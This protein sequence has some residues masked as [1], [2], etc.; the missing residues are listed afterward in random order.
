MTEHG[1][2][3]RRACRLICFDRSTARY[4]CRRPDDAALRGRLRALAA[5]RR[6][7]GYRRLGVLLAREGV[8]VNHKKLFRLYREERLAVRRR[9]GRKRAVGTRRPMT[10][11]QVVNER[12]SLDF[13][14]DALG[15]GRRFRVL[16]VLDD[17]SREC[18]ALIV[19]TS[20]SGKRVARELDQLIAWRGRPA[21]I[22]S[23]NGTELTSN[24]I[25]CWAEE[26]GVEW[27]YIAP[28]KPVQN[29]FAESFIG[30]F[31]DEC[32]NESLFGSLAAA[33]RLIAHWRADY[34][35]TRPHSSL[36]NR[37]PIAYANLS[38]PVMRRGGS[39]E[40][41]GGSAPRLVAPQTM[42]MQ[43]ATGL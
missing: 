10:I 22:V 35:A 11:P 27:H 15:D 34:N 17:F 30:R 24:A 28:G 21:M 40:L 6:R 8:V 5:E 36:G 23:D 41:F 16:C 14:S 13:V 32:L 3:Q 29:A 12:W 38:D 31:R 2:S 20:I 26:R 7:F 4:R 43:P 18:L 39:P 25:L 1:F 42:R 9:G 37:T 33:R 19:D